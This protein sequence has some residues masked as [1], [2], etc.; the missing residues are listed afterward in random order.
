[1]RS[2]RSRCKRKKHGLDW[3]DIVVFGLC[4]VFLYNLSGI[5]L[6]Y[7]DVKKD[8]DSANTRLEMAK[9][10][11]E[12]LKEERKKLNDNSHIEKI[13]REE[14]GMTK[15]GEMPYISTKK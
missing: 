3:F 2:V 14:L 13:A 9:N 15:Q 5:F 4:A 1:M 8:Y 12:G 6:R 7:S 11:N 10:L